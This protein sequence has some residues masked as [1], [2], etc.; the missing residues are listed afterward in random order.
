MTHEVSSLLSTS[1]THLVSLSN[2]NSD[3]NT[4]LKNKIRDGSPSLLESNKKASLDDYEGQDHKKNQEDRRR[5]SQLMHATCISSS[6]SC[7]LEMRNFKKITVKQ[8]SEGHKERND[9]LHLESHPGQSLKTKPKSVMSP[10]ILE[11]KQLLVHKTKDPQERQEVRS[12]SD[13][14]S[15]HRKSKEFDGEKRKRPRTAFTSTQIQSLE[16]EFDRSEIFREVFFRNLR[17]DL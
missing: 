8:S 2:N 11:K 9:T 6:S 16:D 5:M 14:V 1:S 4:G 10:A 3:K 17:L 7:A 13:G 15:S 12:K